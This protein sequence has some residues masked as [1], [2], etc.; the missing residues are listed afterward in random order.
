MRSGVAAAA[1]STAEACEKREADADGEQGT[2]ESLPRAGAT[3]GA[4]VLAV[5]G[6]G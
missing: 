2:A 1:V 4:S 6:V 3:G 5:G